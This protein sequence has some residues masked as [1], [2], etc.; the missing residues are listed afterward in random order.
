MYKIFNEVSPLWGICPF[1]EVKDHLIDCRAKSKLPA[2]AKSIIIFAF[3]YLLPE[4]KYEGL[5]VSKYAA[6]QDYHNVVPQKL[7]DA[8]VKLQEMFP[9]ESFAYFSDNSPIPEVKAAT[10]AGVGIKGTNGL[11]ITEKYGSFVFLG[12]IVTTLSLECNIKEI[13][14][15][16]NC[17]KCTKA[18][19]AGAINNGII[20]KEICLSH[21]TQK[22]SE[23]TEEEADMIKMS[24][25]AWGCDIC[26]DVCPLNKNAD[27]TDIEEFLSS[28]NSQVDSNTPIEG[29]AFAWRGEKVIKRNLEILESK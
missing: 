26:Q 4:D 14:H 2:D 15:C 22:K 10:T 13:S 29:R 1:D 3:P 18:C 7:A 11:L 27:T 12:E 8:V 19:P 6:V 24:G 21:I 23:L 25:C 16:I 5:N 20:N 28:A 17:G 9:S